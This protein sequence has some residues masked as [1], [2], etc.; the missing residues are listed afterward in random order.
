MVLF[1]FLAV[2]ISL[3]GVMAPGP[4]SAAALVSGAS[5]QHAG[6]RLAIGHG[7]VEFPLMLLIAGGRGTILSSESAQIGISLVGGLFLIFL[8]VR[9]LKSRRAPMAPS[10][11]YGGGKP[12]W[13]GIILTGGNP[14]F[15]VWWA[16]VGTNLT[17]RSL[18][19]SLLTFG[20]F[21]VVH[22]LCDLVWLEA[23][24]LA[25]FKGSKL[26]GDRGQLYINSIC[27]IAMFV[28][29]AMF[30]VDGVAGLNGAVE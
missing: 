13:T 27:G 2:G 19:F 23:L 15:I 10:S 26:M 4:M 16:T 5:S 28:F 12:I 6:L 1:L 3:T 24:S 20:L 29:G 30:I 25:S 21:A 18:E 9:L 8:G 7:I 17:L 22:W 11:A 14:Y